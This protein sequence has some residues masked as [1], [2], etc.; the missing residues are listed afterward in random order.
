MNLKAAVRYYADVYGKAILWCYAI[1]YGIM[2][3]VLCLNWVLGG[4]TTISAGLDMTSAVFFFVLGLNAFKGTLR[5]FIQNGLSRR[6]LWLGFICVALAGSVAMAILDALTMLL[7]TRIQAN[8]AVF[9]YVYPGNTTFVN[10]LWGAALYFALTCTGFSITSLY[11]RLS[12]EFKI[13]VSILVPVLL[14]MVLPIVDALLTQ[15]QLMQ[16][17]LDFCL[18]A[19]GLGTQTPNALR[20]V[21]TFLGV[22]VIAMGLG[23]LFTRRAALKES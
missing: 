21:G 3:L 13:L 23:Y 17:L 16:G 18:K 22:S 4:Q 8:S 6:T 7:W 15:V 1:V 20:A 12:K 5:L 2:L 14:F 9:A 10:M 19:M 11:Y